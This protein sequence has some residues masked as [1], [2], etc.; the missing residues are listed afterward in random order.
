MIAPLRRGHRF[1]FAG[2]TLVLPVVFVA[3]I[4][5]RVEMPVADAFPMDQDHQRQMIEVDAAVPDPLLYQSASEPAVG[6]VLP[7]DARLLGA[8]RSQ[9]WYPG[10]G[11]L[12]QDEEGVRFVYSL[13]DQRVVRILDESEWTGGRQ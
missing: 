5:G 10:S 2:L 6:G 3:S 13:I 4:R 1:V 8:L 7:A 9:T 11:G 12:A